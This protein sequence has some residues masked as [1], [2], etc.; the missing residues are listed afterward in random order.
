[1]W[2]NLF[3]FLTI[4]EFNDKSSNWFFQDKISIEG[5]ALKQLKI[6]HSVWII[7]GDQRN[8]IHIRYF[9]FLFDFFDKSKPKLIMASRIHSSLYPSYDDQIFSSKYNLEIIYHP[10]Y[11]QKV[12]HYKDANTKLNGWEFHE[13]NW[14]SIFLNTSVNE[15]CWHFSTTIRK[16]FGYIM[17]HE[18]N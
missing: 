16:S 1:M 15:K 8:S 12:C 3:L 7:P 14:Q 4:V 11:M 2:G 5:D 17:S 10:P 13:F 9:L 18:L 6:W